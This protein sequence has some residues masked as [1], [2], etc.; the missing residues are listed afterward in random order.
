MSVMTNFILHFLIYQ[1]DIT[2][3]AQSVM[4]L[5]LQCRRYEFDFWVGLLPLFTHVLHSRSSTDWI[6]KLSGLRF[7]QQEASEL[8]ILTQW[9]NQRPSFVFTLLG[10]IILRFVNTWPSW[11]RSRY[12]HWSSSHMF[13]KIF[14]EYNRGKEWITII[15]K[16]DL[17]LCNYVK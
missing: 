9:K 2:L 10:A 6:C 11:C 4:N 12:R 14:K 5:Y 15:N 7:C 1:M 16:H 8:Y 13:L 17:G 3:L